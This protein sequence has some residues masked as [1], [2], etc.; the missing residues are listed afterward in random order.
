M[1]KKKPKY[2]PAPT[3]EELE[4]IEAGEKFSDIKAN[5]VQKA[6]N[7]ALGEDISEIEELTENVEVVEPKK[8]KR[9][10]KRAVYFWLGIF[11]T[12]MSIIGIIFSVN[13]TFSAIRRITDNTEQKNEF[14][15]YVYPLVIVDCPTYDEISKL[16]VDVVLRAAAWN[17][18]INYDEKHSKYKNDNGYITVPASDME[19]EATNLFGKGIVF[20]HQTLGDPTLYFN[21]DTATNSYIIPISPTNLSYKPIVNDIKKINDT[22]FELKVGYYPPTQ[23]WLPENKKNIADKYLKYTLVKDGKKYSVVS[24]QEYESDVTTTAK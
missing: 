24:I 11:V 15:R 20:D 3:S 10:M 4:R 5:S 1:A 7:G 12:F 23:D 13:F 6:I 9:S 19:V 18:I 2:I 14:A 21:Y 17:I 8:S 22:K 16:P